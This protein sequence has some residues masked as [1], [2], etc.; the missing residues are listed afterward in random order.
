MAKYQ[1]LYWKEI[2]AQVKVVEEGKRTVSRQLPERFQIEIDR[3][4][5]SEGLTGTDEYLNEWRW[6]PKKER[7]GTAEE[8]ADA[9]VRELEKQIDFDEGRAD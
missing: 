1:I 3:I 5:M 2:P 4:A 6:T 7:P 8:V 9:L